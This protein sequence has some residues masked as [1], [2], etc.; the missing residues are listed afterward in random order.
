MLV[1]VYFVLVGLGFELRSNLQTRRSTMSLLV[2]G[3]LI[4]IT[5][6]LQIAL[7]RID[8]LTILK[9]VSIY[10]FLL[11]VFCGF[12]CIRFPLS[13]LNPKIFCCFCFYGARDRT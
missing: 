5:L 6:N 13:W 4:G 8:I 11:A 3:I 2:L 9:R 12:H 7:D 10:F 1:F